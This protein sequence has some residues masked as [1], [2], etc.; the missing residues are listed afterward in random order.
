MLLTDCPGGAFN[1]QA[2]LFLSLAVEVYRRKNSND[3]L[4][5][6]LKYDATRC[7]WHNCIGLQEIQIY[8]IWRT[9][10]M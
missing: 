4:E 3:K 10:G 6:R 9:T 1:T 2:I 7:H 5:L 8:P